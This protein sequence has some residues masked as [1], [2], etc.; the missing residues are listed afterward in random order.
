MTGIVNVYSR[1]PA[2]IAQSAATIDALSGGRFTLGIGTSGAQVIEGWHGV[3][4]TKPLGRTRDT[5]DVCRKVWSGDKLVHDGPAVTLPL[6][7][8][9][10]TGLGKPLK[11]MNRPLRQDIPIVI[12]SI[13]PSNVEMTAEIADGWQPIHFVPDRFERVWG[14]ALRAGAAKRSAEL[15]PLDIFGDAQLAIG[16]GA[17]VAAAR[18]A[19]RNTIGFYVGGMGA[20]SKNYYNDLFRRYGWEDEAEK[21]QDLFLSGKRAEAMAAVPDEYLDTAN[22]IGTEGHIKERLGVYAGVGVTHLIVNPTGTKPLDD[23]SAVKA[24][25]G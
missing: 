12:A 10:G 9:Q 8:E 11:F 20:K 1:S 15:A 25:I 14:D 19:A 13:G 22:L 2:L 23:L 4:F 7:P 18:E 6:P 3:P 17:E 21:I 5:I 24:W 16:E